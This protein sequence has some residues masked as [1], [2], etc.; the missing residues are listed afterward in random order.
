LRSVHQPIRQGNLK[1]NK[2]ACLNQEIIKQTKNA[3]GKMYAVECDVTNENSIKAAFQWV[4]DNLGGVD[5]LINNAGVNRF[6]TILTKGNEDELRAVLDTNLTGLLL[7]TKAAFKSMKTRNNHG[8]II[9]INSIVGHKIPFPSLTT[10]LASNVYPSSKYAVRAAS[11]VLRQELI[12]M[13]NDKIRV[14]V[15]HN[16]V[17]RLTL[18]CKHFIS[19]C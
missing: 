3:T 4:E 6:T 14:S 10:R 12:F 7:C 15:R 13:K 16:Y 11:E 5:I 2:P 9:N 8:F 17:E 18:H 19:E 1:V